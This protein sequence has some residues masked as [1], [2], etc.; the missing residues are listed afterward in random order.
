VLMTCPRHHASTNKQCRH[1][2]LEVNFVL[3]IL[4]G[5]STLTNPVQPARTSSGTEKPFLTH[6]L[7]MS[8]SNVH[9]HF[10]PQKKQ[11]FLYVLH[12]LHYL[13]APHHVV[14]LRLPCY[15]MMPCFNKHSAWA[16]HGFMHHLKV[17]TSCSPLAAGP[18]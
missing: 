16:C 14:Q 4:D 17:N 12:C 10:A 8:G 18:R 11:G 9:R 5:S 2:Q 13:F 6:R 15:L 7:P 3:I 1:V